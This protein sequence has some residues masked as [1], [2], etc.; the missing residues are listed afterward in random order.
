[1]HAVWVGRLYMQQTT[2]P[3]HQIPPC[4]TQVA[5]HPSMQSDQ[6]ELR[7]CST[8]ILAAVILATE[9]KLPQKPKIWS[10]C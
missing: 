4:T 3:M 2:I 6:A 9:K 8:T 10:F 7:A 1:M 5:G